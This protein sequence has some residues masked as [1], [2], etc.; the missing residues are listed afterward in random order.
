MEKKRN[1]GM[2]EKGYTPWNYK[3]KGRL[4]R[5][6]K[7][8]NGKLILNSHFV[9]LKYNNLKEVPK[10][11]IIHHK[12]GDSLNDNIENLVLMTDKAHKQLQK[13]AGEELVNHSQEKK[14]KDLRLGKLSG[15]TNHR[16]GSK[17]QDNKLI[18]EGTHPDNY[19]CGKKFEFVDSVVDIL[20]GLLKRSYSFMSAVRLINDV[21]KETCPACSKDNYSPQGTDSCFEIKNP[22]RVLEDT[23]KGLCEFGNKGYVPEEDCHCFCCGTHNPKKFKAKKEFKLLH[24]IDCTC[25]ACSKDNHSPHVAVSQSEKL[26]GIEDTRKGCGKEIGLINC[27]DINQEKEIMGLCRACSKKEDTFFEDWDKTINPKCSK[28]GEEK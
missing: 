5:K 1:K 10:G 24:A 13:K 16:K 20:N 8:F 21:H 3:G 26:T 7:R 14:D 15:D 19:I 25:P 9:W 6:Y 12:D 27:G 11:Y 18:D 28:K 4:K 22:K 2:F 23:R 17:L